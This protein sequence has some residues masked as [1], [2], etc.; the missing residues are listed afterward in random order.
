MSTVP[1]DPIAG[2]RHRLTVEDFHH[3]GEAGVLAP[4]ARVELI[5]G[6]IIDMTPIGSAHASR[7]SR[8]AD[9]FTSALH[10]VAIVAVQNPVR[11]GARSEPQ[12]DLAVLRYRED[13]YAAAHPAPADII[14]LVEVADTTARFDRE[15][16]V[17][18]YARH[19]ISEV[20]LLD[21][22]GGVME[23]C[24]APQ[25]GVYGEITTH[26]NGTVS[27]RELPQ[28]VVDVGILLG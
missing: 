25:G 2:R 20:W 26:R 21:L 28:V 19:G 4:E 3:M 9:L 18:L 1:A 8:L 10:G 13:F 17:P 15:V 12:P 27:P 6:E 11:L 22:E 16:K 14:L 7:V 5:E 24:R 23:V